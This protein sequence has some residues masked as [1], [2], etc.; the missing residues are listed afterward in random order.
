MQGWRYSAS[1]GSR[2]RPCQPS[3]M[4]C[5]HAVRRAGSARSSL[6]GHTGGSRAS[7]LR[8]ASSPMRCS[9]ARMSSRPHPAWQCTMRPRSPSRSARV[10]LRPVRDPCTGQKHRHHRPERRPPPHAATA[11]SAAVMSAPTCKRRGVDQAGARCRCSRLPAPAYPRVR[12]TR[13]Y[14]RLA[15]NRP[16]LRRERLLRHRRG[17]VLVRAANGGGSARS[18]ARRPLPPAGDWR[19]LACRVTR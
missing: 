4:R 8:P 3:Q 10:R 6:R 9:A 11:I 5:A 2:A 14:R 18:L 19:Q 13:R 17:G 15:G 16:Q 12:A 1:R 7:S